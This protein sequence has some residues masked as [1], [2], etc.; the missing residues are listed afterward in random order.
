MITNKTQPSPWNYRVIAQSAGEWPRDLKHGKQTSATM[1]CR[2]AVPWSG[3]VPAQQGRPADAET[4]YGVCIPEKKSDVCETTFIRI[5]RKNVR[6]LSIQNPRAWACPQNDDPSIELIFS[7]TDILYCQFD[8][9]TRSTLR[10]PFPGD[11]GRT[12]NQMTTCLTWKA[13]CYR[14][15][16]N[17]NSGT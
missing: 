14:Y 6:D 15:S 13:L 7:P 11:R 9:R 3:P 12:G 10:I 4:M 16:Q 5:H 1:F 2:W 17:T 8:K